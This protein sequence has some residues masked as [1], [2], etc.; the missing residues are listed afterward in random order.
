MSL[1]AKEFRFPPGYGDNRIV[2]L[3]R[4]PWWVFAYWEIR[5][6]VEEAITRDIAVTGQKAA[7]SILRVYD[8]TDIEFSGANA[9]SHFDIELKNMASN[10]YINVNSSDRSWIVEIGVLAANN[11]FF[12]LARSNTVRTPPFGMSEV[13]DEEWLTQEDECWKMFSMICL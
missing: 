5:R 10:W 11:Q 12:P 7:G 6:D 9:H 2:L 13:F 1:A 4:D 8:V 3:V